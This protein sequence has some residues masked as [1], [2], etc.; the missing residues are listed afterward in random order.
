MA[1]GYAACL[2]AI[3]LAISVLHAATSGDWS[4]DSLASAAVLALVFAGIGYCIG[5]VADSLI[6]Q[7]VEA[8]FRHAVER[9]KREGGK[10]GQTKQPS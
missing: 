9:Y 1:R 6:R 8:D 4:A 10:S 2:G 7:A 3:A 5:L